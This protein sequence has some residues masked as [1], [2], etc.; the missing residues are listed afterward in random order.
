M[1]TLKEQGKTFLALAPTHMACRVLGEGTQ[2]LHSFFSGITRKS[3]SK[4]ASFEYIII[5]EK[6][7]IKEMFFRML[8]Q[9]KN[10]TK[11]KIILA[12]D[13]AQLPP[14]CDR[15]EFDYE[16]SSVVHHICDVYKVQ[17]THCRRADTEL[18]DMCKN[19]DDVKTSEFGKV[20]YP[21]CI[22][23]T[24]LFVKM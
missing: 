20:M 23:S 4:L 3:V 11:C 15:S 9:I 24:M 21:R 18:F 10:N 16:N 19:V 6:S 17:L 22:S 13:W 5:D 1:K 7:M 14:V 12:G 8:L 2:T